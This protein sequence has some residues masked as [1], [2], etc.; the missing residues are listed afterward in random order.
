MT[1]RILKKLDEYLGK[2][3][4][5]SAQRHLEYW[6]MES[7]HSGNDRNALLVTNELMG[8][9]RKLGE[10][11]KA[12]KYADSALKL[13]EKMDIGDNIGAATSYINVATVYKAFDMAE[14]S[15]PLFERALEIYSSSIDPA[16]T[17]FGGLY[18]NMALALTDLCLFDR[19]REYY[20]RAIDTMQQSDGNQPEIAITYLNLASLAE[21]ESGLEAGEQEI[22]ALLERARELLNVS[23][24]RT[25]GDYAFVCEKCAPVFGYYGYFV[26]KNE[27]SERARKIYEGS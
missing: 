1:E 5:I 22:T 26:Y 25:D 13:I 6:L 3:D 27:L 12:L 2:N 8:L 23:A 18:N 24:C 11:E 14:R 19:A 21:A 10:R 17:R 9:N 4:Y 15:I 7:E 16:D 20:Q